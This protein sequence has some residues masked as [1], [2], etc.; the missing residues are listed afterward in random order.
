MP[1]QRAVLLAWDP[2]GEPLL[3]ETPDEAEA[4]LRDLHAQLSVAGSPTL[5]VLE[6]EGEDTSLAVG[7]GAESAMA[8]W[9]GDDP[10]EDLTSRG[11]GDDED[12]V[13]FLYAGAE[14][15][16]PGTV[17]IDVED[18]FAAAHEYASTGQRPTNLAWQSI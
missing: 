13:A 17:S 14:S 2:K 7:L 5:V 12:L 4:Q 16:Y 8:S 11:D 18:A 10:A 3:V 9:L 1:E 15:E 6:R